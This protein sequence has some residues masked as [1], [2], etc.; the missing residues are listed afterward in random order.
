MPQ[1]RNS[2][3]S[4]LKHCFNNDIRV[5]VSHIGQKIAIQQGDTKFS[6][7]LHKPVETRDTS[8]G[9]ATCCGL[10]AAGWTAGVRHLS[11]LH[12]FQIGSGAHPASY[13]VGTGGSFPGVKLTTHLQLV[14]RSRMVELY[15][16]SWHSA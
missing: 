14:P 1:L 9:T 10:R 8:V 2:E 15:T 13:S 16:S 4:N 5:G 11:L 3:G 7:A 12:S 6:P